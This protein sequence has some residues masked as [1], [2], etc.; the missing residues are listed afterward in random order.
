MLRSIGLNQGFH[1][2]S[3]KDVDRELKRLQAKQENLHKIATRTEGSLAA[4]QEGIK[5]VERM[6]TELPDRRTR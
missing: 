3:L 4:I 2:N 5:R 1:A 6:I